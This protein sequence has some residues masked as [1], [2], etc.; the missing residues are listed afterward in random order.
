MLH[1]ILDTNLILSCSRWV[2]PKLRWLTP[3][4]GAL[5]FEI[6]YPRTPISAGM[7][8]LTSGL[9]VSASVWSV[10]TVARLG[11]QHAVNQRGL[12]L[13]CHRRQI[14]AV[15]LDYGIVA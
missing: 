9:L 5:V 6:K 13:T 2:V 8:S 15:S 3:H 11:Y 4:V 10:F 12:C 14:A 7:A 1:A